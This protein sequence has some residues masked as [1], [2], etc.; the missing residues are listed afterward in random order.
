MIGLLKNVIARG[1]WQARP[2]VQTGIIS[3]ANGTA[4]AAKQ[5]TQDIN[6][7]GTTT[8]SNNSVLL[9]PVQGAGS[10][11]VVQNVDDT[12]TL[13]VFAAGGG[14]INTVTTT[15]AISTLKA[16]IFVSI[17]MNEWVGFIPPSQGTPRLISGGLL[18][19]Q[20]ERFLR[21]DNALCARCT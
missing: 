3:A 9:P 7:V 10:V 11:V 1:G 16:G 15:F 6:I 17:A 12:E 8:S 5:L 18:H 2:T 13:N 19:G 4:T 21:A 14:K 20:A